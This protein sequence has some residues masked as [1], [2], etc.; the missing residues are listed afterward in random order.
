METLSIFDFMPE[1][2]A[3]KYKPLKSTDWNGQKPSY[4]VGMSVPPIMMKRVVTRLIEKGVFDY[5]LKRKC[6]V[7]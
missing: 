3:S 1:E 6:H 7:G 2:E 5:K 4:I